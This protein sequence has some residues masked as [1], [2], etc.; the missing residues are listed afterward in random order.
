MSLVR[1]VFMIPQVPK[2]LKYVLFNEGL[3]GMGEQEG[4]GV[5]DLT[6]ANL[7]LEID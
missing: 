5:S 4:A 1:V 2:C 7:A 3:V 6:I